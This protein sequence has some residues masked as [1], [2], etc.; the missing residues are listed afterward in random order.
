MVEAVRS[1][2]CSLSMIH[3]CYQWYY[4]TDGLIVS[5]KFA[6][7]PLQLLEVRISTHVL[8]STSIN[9]DLLTAKSHLSPIV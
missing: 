4:H 1:V 6:I 5:R 8:T 3:H 9:L 2:D 7:V